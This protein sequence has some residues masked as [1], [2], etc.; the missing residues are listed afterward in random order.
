MYEAKITVNKMFTKGRISPYLYGSFVEHMGRVVYTGIYEPNHPQA[1]KDG[2]R[3]DVIEKVK[4][5]GV[6]CIRYPGGNFVSCY[7][8]KDGVGSKEL[9]PR[10]RDIAWKSI[11]T[12]EFGVDEFMKWISKCDAVPILAV[13][14]GTKGIE[15]AVSLLEYCNL[16]AGTIYS[17]YRAANGSA[18][19]YAVPFW[20]LGNEMD[21]KW[22]IGHKTPEAYGVLAAQ[23]AHAMKSMDA[24]I[25]LIVC[26]SSSAETA[27][28]TEW[29]KVVLDA[30]Y[31]FVD[32]I[33]LHQYYGGQEWGTDEFLAQSLELENYID[34]VINI[35]DVV[36]SRKGVQRKI[37]ISFDEW[38]VWEVSGDKIA[39]DVGKRDWEIAPAISEQIYT[40]EDALLFASMLMA[41][42]KRADRVK[43]ACQS[44]LANVSAA[45]MTE[46][47]GGVWLQT[48]Y[49]PF[50]YMAKY[51]AGTVLQA[52]DEI[53]AYKV[54]R[55]YLV[56]YL[57]YVAI[58]NSEEKEV[59]IFAVN[60]KD[61][62]AEL[63]IELQGFK[64][65]RIIEE[66]SLESKSIKDTNQI[67]HM[68]VIPSE[69]EK[70]TISLQTY[71]GTVNPFSW[72]MIRISVESD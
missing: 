23:T 68:T 61:Q 67:N 22:Q 51:G 28:Y 5:M 58:F 46:E 43:I 12:N 38:G 32:Y 48:I 56:P 25:R 9:R 4:G 57:D 66:I 62:A 71:Q 59:V 60:R 65:N 40:M 19:P 11:E 6:T 41:M 27:T 20:C 31:E 49:Y 16:P 52:V 70:G 17:D 24:D 10:R 3:K 34:T 14:L 69:S 39:E 21:G 45:I 72:R 26:G 42:L 37:N 29:E 30:S 35:C 63:K 36:R 15:N 64:S 50:S 1:D 13:N 55:G 2:F 33:A 18:M 7:D 53:P 44:L 54:K 47:M 8:W